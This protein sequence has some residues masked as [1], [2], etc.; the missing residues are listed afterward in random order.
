MSK[1]KSNDSAELRA[2]KARTELVRTV[3]DAMRCYERAVV[4]AQGDE[5]GE[6]ADAG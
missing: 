1:R 3:L 4:D 6:N 5:H 2:I